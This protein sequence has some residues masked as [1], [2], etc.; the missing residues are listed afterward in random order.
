MRDKSE[1]SDPLSPLPLTEKNGKGVEAN[2][3]TE[4]E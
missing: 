4:K 1:L 3:Q 2:E